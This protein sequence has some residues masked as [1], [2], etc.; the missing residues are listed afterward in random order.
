MKKTREKIPVLLSLLFGIALFSIIFY[1]MLT[2][3]IRG[4]ANQGDFERMMIWI[5]A[6]YQNNDDA[7]THFHWVNRYFS[8][9]PPQFGNVISSEIPFLFLARSINT[10]LHPVLFD[11]NV[12]G[13]LHTLL[14]CI[15]LSV[16][17]Y[18][19]KKYNA[20]YGYLFIPFAAIV[21][22]DIG[23][24]AY[25]NSFYQESA[26]VLFLFTTLTI[27]VK[28]IQE[29]NR[30]TAKGN[31][32]LY[33]ISSLLL[34]SA[35][36]Q[37]FILCV[38]VILTLYILFYSKKRKLLLGVLSF[39]ITVFSFAY[40]FLGTPQIVKDW[41]IYNSVCAQILN[42]TGNPERALRILK[43]NQNFLKYRGLF[44]EDIHSGINDPQ[45]QRFFT[46]GIFPRIILYYIKTPNEFIS[47]SR[48]IG[49]YSFSTTV[50]YLGYYEHAPGHS[51]GEQPKGFAL[52]SNF[53]QM[54]FPHGHRI[55][56]LVMGSSLLLL[57][58]V[59]LYKKNIAGALIL[60][61]SVS[62]CS[63]FLIVAF[64]EGISGSIEKV[65]LLFDLLFDLLLFIF[66]LC[67]YEGI[68]KLI[69]GT[70]KRNSAAP[71][72]SL[73][74]TVFS[75]RVKQFDMSLRSLTAHS[76]DAHLVEL[77]VFIDYPDHK[78]IQAVIEK[79]R[80]YFSEVTVF[81]AANKRTPINHSASRRNFL[82]KQAKGS[83]IIFSEPE[84]FHI[85]NSIQLCL[86]HIARHTGRTWFSGSV[87]AAEDVASSKGE[88]IDTGKPLKNFSAI[89]HIPDHQNFVT[90]SRFRKHYHLI[91]NTLY[92]TPFY[93]ALFEKKYFLQCKGLNQNLKVRGY[94]EMEF[95]KRFSRFGGSI[96]IDPSLTM[97]HLPH[98]RNL[99][100][101]SQVG[102]NLYN[103]TVTF[104][105]K[106]HVGHIDD[107]DVI[108]VSKQSP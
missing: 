44:A 108:G 83:Y 30:K 55:I 13:I 8:L 11:I 98:K 66:L 9:G 32:L 46:P 50:G 1:S 23:Y 25:F 12:V 37:Y 7:K 95:Y 73:L 67:I 43:L 87:Y 78:P 96:I 62:A 97:I 86:S 74:I 17:F 71:Q 99:N 70:M 52:W 45:L 28:T 56:M 53:K 22:T 72:L 24:T 65:L 103:S 54:A 79:Y 88:L 92:S 100:K 61:I 89:L 107:A 10:W 94:E 60:F 35:K 48:E 101:E 90:S 6:T 33:C 40:Y 14:F 19:L 93:F 39:F 51:P 47:L 63:Q 76:F 27:I 77:I 26:G 64:S 69:Q 2:P 80:R 82:A 38:P 36:A 4:I 49:K 81:V 59:Y 21:L 20:V 31:I 104:D 106:Q 5:G 68:K 91:D 105:E 3:P 102:W 42:S 29:K 16:N 15:I 34:I 85:N 18:Y 58:Y 41:N 84:M 75:D 57:L